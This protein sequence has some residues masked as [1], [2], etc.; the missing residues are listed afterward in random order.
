MPAGETPRLRADARRNRGRVVDAATALFLEHGP[1]A[2]LEGVARAAG[3]GIGT[4]YR[5][6]PGR[7]DLLAAVFEDLM[8]D[9]VDD[10]RAA[11]DSA[12]TAWDG[13]VRATGWTPSI[14][15][16][17]H[18]ARGRRVEDVLTSAS[19][20]ALRGHLDEMLTLITDLVERAQAEGSMRRDVG[21]GDVVLMT[22]AL[23]RSLPLDGDAAANAYTRAHA[24][25]AAG[26][27]A[28]AALPLPGAPVSLADLPL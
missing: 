27:R 15:R 25:L 24:I 6:F 8:A 21:A 26:L 28:D 3:V 22:G 12:P 18:L 23:S 2:P 20:P 9:V 11:R 10:V 19:A 4:L 14:R 5:H 13:L 17:L 16:I 1:D 7:D